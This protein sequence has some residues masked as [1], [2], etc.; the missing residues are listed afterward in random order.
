MYQVI[1][2]YGDNEPWWFFEDWRQ[3]I[4]SQ[5]EFTDAVEAK[6]FYKKEW[7]RL[8]K[9]FPNSS[10]KANFLS[11][12]W[13]EAD[14]RWCE[15]CD[16]YIQ[17]YTGLALLKDYQ[18]VN[19]TSERDLFENLHAEQKIKSCQRIKQDPAAV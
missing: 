13:K 2:M 6:A 8:A 12:F 9:E 17:Q 10:A 18:P 16:D 7:Q 11:A 19:E 15:E 5:A 3:D 1:V 4:R 14:E